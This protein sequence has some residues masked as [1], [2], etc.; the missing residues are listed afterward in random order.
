MIIKQ[1]NRKQLIT[2]LLQRWY[3]IIGFS[4]T[5]KVYYATCR[6]AR[7]KKINPPTMPITAMAQPSRQIEIIKQKI[8]ELLPEAR[9][10][11]YTYEAPAPLN[12]NDFVEVFAEDHVQCINKI[13]ETMKKMHI[14]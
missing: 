13:C 3:S 6:N 12:P 1:K 11:D 9:Y 4:A 7:E 2:F 5:E 10:I 8:I 14:T